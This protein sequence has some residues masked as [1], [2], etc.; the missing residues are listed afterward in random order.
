MFELCFTGSAL[1]PRFPRYRRISS[2]L[3]IARREAKRVLSL[4][5]ETPDWGC[6]EA[7]VYGPG[8]GADGKRLGNRSARA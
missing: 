6:H 1:R 5:E 4:I 3:P 2:S 7:I 8:C